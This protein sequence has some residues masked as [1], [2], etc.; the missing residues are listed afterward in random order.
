ME[1]HIRR[2]I[3]DHILRSKDYT[4]IIDGFH[5]IPKHI[6]GKNGN[7]LDLPNKRFEL[8]KNQS[9]YS[10]NFKEYL[11][12]DLKEYNIQECIVIIRY[13]DLWKSIQNKYKLTGEN[14]YFSLDY[15]LPKY[16]LAIEIDSNLHNLEYDKARDE[17]N[18]AIYGITTL[19]FYE[20]GENLFTKKLDLQKLKDNTDSYINYCNQW[21]LNLNCLRSFDNYSDIIYQNFIDDYKK[22]LEILDKLLNYLGYPQNR[23]INTEKFAIVEG[24]LSILSKK[25]VNTRKLEILFNTLFH[26]KSLTIYDNIFSNSLD[27]IISVVKSRYNFNWRKFL[28]KNNT[29]PAWIPLVVTIPVPVKVINK[30]LP[31]T[32]EDK[33][34]I[35]M[36]IK[37]EFQNP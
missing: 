4:E 31:M 13:K 17:Y 3:L 22:E 36:V 14:L 35:D 5:T 15:Y 18:Y 2:L 24:E 34:I 6:L 23:F 21:N 27:T 30:I 29:I 20:F 12:K 7:K 37:G 1:D 8:L 28:N 25:K 33:L 11:E 32:K 16:K 10:R 26:N 19:R 9:S